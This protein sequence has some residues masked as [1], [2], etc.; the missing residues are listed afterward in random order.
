MSTQFFFFALSTTALLAYRR[1]RPYLPTLAARLADAYAISGGVSSLFGGLFWATMTL[2]LGFLAVV[3]GLRQGD[4]LESG[5]GVIALILD[6]AWLAYLAPWRA[7]S[8]PG[9]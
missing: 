3:D 7:A 2:L 4:S 9:D 1:G 5:A 8:G 6:I